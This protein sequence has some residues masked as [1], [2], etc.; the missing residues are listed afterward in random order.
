[1]LAAVA[2]F[3]REL[4]IERINAG[5]KAARQRGEKLGRPSKKHLYL[6]RVRALLA[7]GCNAAEICRRL[8]LPYSSVGDL[9]REL[10]SANQ[11][12]M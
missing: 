10:K 2:E 8:R 1:M 6:D 9:V 4:I 3:E 11:A 12:K 5:I 7:E